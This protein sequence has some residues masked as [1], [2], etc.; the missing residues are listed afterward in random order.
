MK[1]AAGK[2]G[3]SQR[4]DPGGTIDRHGSTHLNA[5]AVRLNNNS[6]STL[7]GL[8]QVLEQIVDDPMRLRWLDLSWNHFTTI[9]PM[10]FK[11]PDISV[12]YQHRNRIDRLA[13]IKK[14]AELKNLRKLI[15]HSNT[16]GQ[17][18]YYRIHVPQSCKLLRSLDVSGATQ[19][20]REY[21]EKVKVR[22]R[23]PASCTA[24]L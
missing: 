18:P 4:G 21:A 1:G 17:D 16:I 10:L 23:R 6:I 8:D 12:L 20:S 9:E 3:P 7:A 14:F 13:E 19:R 15:L 5:V 2:G 22:T 11:C 24:L